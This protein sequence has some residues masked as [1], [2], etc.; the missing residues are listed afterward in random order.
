MRVIQGV[1]FEKRHWQN[2]IVKRDVLDLSQR[3]KINR[4]SGTTLKQ[5]VLRQRTQEEE[6]RKNKKA[7][8][9][10]V[11]ILH[12]F[13]CGTILYSRPGSISVSTK[14]FIHIISS[15]CRWIHCITSALIVCILN[16]GD[17]Y[18]AYLRFL[19]SLPVC[20]HRCSLCYPRMCCISIWY[21]R[22]ICNV[23]T[24]CNETERINSIKWR[25][26]NITVSYRRHV[27]KSQIEQH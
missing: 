16:A 12:C 14:A 2:S 13:L 27:W 20:K 11:P 9:G 3:K 4:R 10:I 19:I 21:L 22:T 24:S 1:L 15:L 5:Q 7:V 26:L 6:R 25:N 23:D 17:D 18:S 8:Q